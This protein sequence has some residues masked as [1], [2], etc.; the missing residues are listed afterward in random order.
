[1]GQLKM[2]RENLSTRANSGTHDPKCGQRH[3]LWKEPSAHDA[4]NEAT[5]QEPAP[6]PQTNE[7]KEG[8]E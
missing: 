1:M 7:A 5:G 6:I 3:P 4:V 8:L 2:L